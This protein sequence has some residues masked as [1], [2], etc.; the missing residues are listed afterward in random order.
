M[1]SLRSRLAYEP[2]ELKFGTSG[3]RGEVIH[4][5]QL[6]LYINALAELTYLQGLPREEGGI[7]RGE[8]FYFARDLRPSSYEYV[9]EQGGRGEIAQ[10]IER[11]IWDAGMLPV[12]L[13][14]LPT[15]ALAHYAFA[16]HKGSVMITGSHI[17][18]D[19][20]GYK[21]QTARGELLKAHEAPIE[22]TVTRVRK[23][24]YEAGY[25]ESPFN[26][27]GLFKSGHTDL[28]AESKAGAL[29][30]IERYTQFFAGSS[31]RGKRLLLYQ[32]SAVGRDILAEILGRLGADVIPAG[33]SETFVPIDTENVDRKQLAVIQMLCD[34][35]SPRCGRIDAVVSTDGD[36]DRPLLL[37]LDDTGKVRFLPGDLLGMVVAE[38]L[39]ADAV[40]V[41]IS[42]NDAV[43]R[44]PLAEVLE[45]KTRIGSPYVIAGMEEALAKGKRAVCGWE[46]NGGFLTGSDFEREGHT[47]AALPTRDAV[48]PI[49]GALF[50]AQ[51]KGISLLERFAQLPRRF[52]SAAL[53]RRFPQTIGKAIVAVFSPSDSDPRNPELD[54]IARQLREFF[55]P[56]KGFGPIA[57]LNYTDGV[58]ITF[59]NGE[60]AHLRPSG[61]ADEM[62]IYA[63]AG[64]LERAETIAQMGI[65]EPDGILRRMEQYALHSR[66]EAKSGTVS[67]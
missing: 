16:R 25:A 34:Q 33:R 67:K 58:R 43:D 32:H 3:R 12:N 22:E 64:T 60:I 18:F 59:Q 8:L 65:A 29:A 38:Y 7:V 54:S 62:R 30:Y 15:P 47:L 19:R 53:L 20:N 26:E 46:A 57:H 42:V 35:V 10:A 6:E 37:A 36:S 51:D 52:G 4:L 13:G 28:P 9:A 23:T 11:A 45:P 24:V 50:A 49:L 48:L 66:A 5:T 39:G 1:E 63:V 41:P 61:N 56:S 27:Q 17:P 40:V 14:T 21:M 2:Q 55:P 31:L 44:G